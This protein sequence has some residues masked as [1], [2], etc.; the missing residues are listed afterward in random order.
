MNLIVKIIIFLVILVICY[1]Y[2]IE[3]IFY[4]LERNRQEKFLQE[5]FDKNE[6]KSYYNL[7][8]FQDKILNK[9]TFLIPEISLKI[10]NEEINFKRFVIPFQFNLINSELF[11]E[12]IDI[13]FKALN[14]NDTTPEEFNLKANILEEIEKH[15]DNERFQQNGDLILGHDFKNEI[16]KIYIDTNDDYLTS[17][18][19]Q[20]DTKENLFFREYKFTN[21]NKIYPEFLDN[22]NLEIKENLMDLFPEENINKIL[23]RV[24]YTKNNNKNNN[25]NENINNSD[26][27]IN[28]GDNNDNIN[29]IIDSIHIN[30][31][32]FIFIDDNVYE[33][34]KNIINK[35]NNSNDKNITEIEYNNLEKIKNKEIAWFSI[36]NKSINITEQEDNNLSINLY[37]R[38]NNK[39]D[40]I[41]QK[42]QFPFLLLNNF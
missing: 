33:K 42:I 10:S 24:K 25:K 9:K 4:R 1:F 11:D 8:N 35:I 40:K 15:L 34:I 17:F 39:Y 5:F 29:Q 2:M 37:I 14:I 23:Y 32:N 28:Q 22:F 13:I 38:G 36:N 31:N 7:L 41:M 3:P 30:L 16:N 20:A 6:M 26:I 12:G 18:E 19:W 21:N 27:D